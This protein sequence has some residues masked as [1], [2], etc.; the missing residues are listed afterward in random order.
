MSQSEQFQMAPVGGASLLDAWER[1][2]YAVMIAPPAP[3]Y[4][5]AP[6]RTVLPQ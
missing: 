2:T 6:R 5:P 3:E 4:R 1:Q